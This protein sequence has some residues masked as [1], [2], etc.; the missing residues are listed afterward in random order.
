[1]TAV[2]P[3]E[4]LPSKEELTVRELNLSSP[5]LKAGAH[6]FG[7]YCDEPSKVS[8]GAYMGICL[9]LDLNP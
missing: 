3:G 4:W 7:K 2:D 6:H 1:M 9:L 5:V 8:A